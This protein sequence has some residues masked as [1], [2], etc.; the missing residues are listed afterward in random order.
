MDEATRGRM[1][2]IEAGLESERESRRDAAYADLLKWVAG[3]EFSSEFDSGAE[4][5]YE[6][7]AHAAEARGG[8]CDARFFADPLLDET[9]FDYWRRIADEILSHVGPPAQGCPPR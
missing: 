1:E 8:L 4:V 3:T 7:A 5:I 6:F 2:A 9:S